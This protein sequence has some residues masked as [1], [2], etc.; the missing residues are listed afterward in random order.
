[1]NSQAS[2]SMYA[3]KDVQEKGMGLVAT[4]N[5]PKGTRILSEQPFITLPAD[6]DFGQGR[7][8]I[9]R[10]L[11][12]LSIDQRRAFL[13]LHNVHRYDD[14]DDSDDMDDAYD[15]ND[16][17]SDDMGKTDNKDDTDNMKD[18][19][20]QCLGIFGTN[21]LPM[22]VGEQ[23]KA[24]IFLEACRINHDC[25]GNAIH[26]W[27]D[28][29]KRHTVH[30][31]R[32][33]DAGEEIT[34]SY[35]LFLMNRESRQKQ[36][37]ESFGF[38]CFCRLCWLPHK[39]RR[40]H[41]QKLEQIIGLGDLC[42]LKYK[43]YPLKAL[44]YLHA[45]AR[46]YS[47]L[48]REDCG[49]AGVYGSAATLAIAHGDLARAR[50]FAERAVIIW[51]T[52][53]GRDS[54]QVDYYI[55]LAQ[56]PT[57]H[58]QYGFSMEWKSAA[59][60]VPEGLGHDDFENWLWKM[61]TPKGLTQPTSPPSQANFSG[62]VDLPYTRSI[63]IG[64]PLKQ[65]QWCFLDEIMEIGFFGRLKFEMK[66]IHGKQFQLCFYTDGGGSEL[67]RTQY[68]TGYTVAVIGA[69]QHLFQFSPPGI[70]HEDPR[71]MKIF[72]LSLSEMLA[73]NSQFRKFAVRQ[74]NNMRTCH[75]CGTNATASSMKRCGKCLSFWYCTKEC[76]MAGWTAKAHKD[77]CKFLR[78]PDLRGLFLIR[79]G[80][81]QD[82]VCFPL[83]VADESY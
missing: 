67:T 25:E 48:G 78:D 65:R 33:I 61:E 5:I 64:G 2:A 34:L 70:R 73:L 4:R 58:P 62:Y 51:T 37:R 43:K 7:R 80:E 75:G 47:E 56:S 17:H 55:N 40:E 82:C 77:D 35:V 66:D 83:K 39:Q 72:P 8:S 3:L 68:K 69:S 11:K 13:L 18:V 81:V 32:D 49:F 21:A 74:R 27:N 41:D 57:L 12:E 1:M 76:Q 79:W 24:G 16:C 36:L 50:V 23:K 53:C 19:W 63:G 28:K 71:M 60:D 59:S 9:C 45:Q 46:I 15:M 38:T 44:G 20:D 31:I 30:A 22:T 29:I 14:M 42:E 54:P 26:Y 52:A 10:Q 6:I